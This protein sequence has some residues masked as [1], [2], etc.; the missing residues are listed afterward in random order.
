M[1]YI[2]YAEV[3][4]S[5]YYFNP[6]GSLGLEITTPS[7]P[8]EDTSWIWLCA[9]SRFRPAPMDIIQLKSK[10]Q[11]ARFAAALHG[12]GWPERIDFEV[13]P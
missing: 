9:W 13:I 6:D 4:L 5:R 12:I 11:A 3:A 10:M 1:G 8:A 2:A 7:Q